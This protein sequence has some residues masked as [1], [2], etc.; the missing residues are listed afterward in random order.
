MGGALAKAQDAPNEY[1]GLPGDN[2]NLYAVMNLFQE[3]ETL[4]DF[5]RKLNDKESRINNIDLNNDN[6]VDYILVVDYAEKEKDIHTIV[7]Q[8]ALNEKEKQDLAVFTVQRFR[9]GSVQIQLIGDEALYGEN[10]ILE[11]NF[12]EAE[13]ERANPGYT[14]NK[15]KRKKSKTVNNNYEIAGWPLIIYIYE[16]EYSIWQS[17]WYWN[18]YPSY[19]D[20]WTPYYF[21]YYYGYHQNLFPVYYRNY[22]HWQYPRHQHY[23]D[24]YTG[25]RSGSSQV[26]VRINNGSYRTT[27]DHPEQIS[28]GENLYNETKTSNPRRPAGSTT[29]R[30]N[31]E[32]GQNTGNSRK[33]PATV[34]GGSD[35]NTST[36]N[37][38]RPVSNENTSRKPASNNSDSESNTR[39]MPSGTDDNASRNQSSGRSTNPSD[40]SRQVSPPERRNY[41]PERQS[42]QPER[43]SSQPE[44]QTSQP[45]RQ[46][47]RPV[48]QPERQPERQVSQPE[49][50]ISQPEQPA[51]QPERRAS[52]PEQPAYQPERRQ[53]SQPEA[54]VRNVEAP[55]PVQHTE[56]VQSQPASRREESQSES[57]PDRSREP[58]RR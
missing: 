27:Y 46:V 20:A 21:H 7:L 39:R 33:P 34:S 23:H 38:R 43:Q 55:A 36:G 22:R 51:Y 16:P 13:T 10:Y 37:P 4:E 45:E 8:V 47:S 41:Q 49:R 58:S 48:Y 9:N 57:A 26:S 31:P 3:S 6:Y 11:P 1:L 5:E 53:I 25:I 14:G 50:R 12:D 18:S 29:T 40:E 42:S 56:P 24:F 15:A 54:P 28:E 2:L 19:W 35:A 17:S 44:R 30:T 52:Q 32:S